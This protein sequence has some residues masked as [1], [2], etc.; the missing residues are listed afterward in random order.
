MALCALH[1]ASAT[2][3]QVLRGKAHVRELDV[4]GRLVVAS[5]AE[6]LDIRVEEGGDV[7]GGTARQDFGEVEVEVM[8]GNVY[9]SFALYVRDKTA[10]KVVGQIY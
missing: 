2:G 1:T 6:P 5:G 9:N 4:R 8:A 7:L 3:I 10:L